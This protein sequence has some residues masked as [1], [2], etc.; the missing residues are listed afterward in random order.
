MPDHRVVESAL[1]GLQVVGDNLVSL[2]RWVLRDLADAGAVLFH[3]RA[4]VTKR[5]RQPLAQLVRAGNDLHRAVF[6]R[7]AV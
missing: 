1:S 6:Y 5:D 2:R 3:V 4:G 7:D